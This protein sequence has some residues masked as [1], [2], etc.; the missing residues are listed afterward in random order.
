MRLQQGTLRIKNCSE[1]DG[2]YNSGTSLSEVYISEAIPLHSNGEPYLI[3]EYE[4]AL[5][6]YN[7][8]A[9]AS[10]FSF[11]GK[12]QMPFLVLRY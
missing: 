6:A 5:L 7:A 3:K 1:A 10:T 8:F 2:I 12:F 11:E 4:R 9:V